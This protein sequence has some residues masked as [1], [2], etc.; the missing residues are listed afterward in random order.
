MQDDNEYLK[1]LDYLYRKSLMLQDT[2]GFNKVLYFY[3]IDSL[4]HI[5]YTAGILAY[6]FGSPKNIIGAEYMRWRIDEEKKGD[7]TK[8]PKFINWLRETK[9]EK[10]TVL[11]S[12]WQMIYDT[13][14]SASYRSFRIVIDPDS[15]A[16]L[17]ANFFNAVIDE[18]FEKEFLKSIYA[19]ASLGTLFTAYCAEH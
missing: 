17:T 6:N 5:D 11:P 7:R 19:E 16:P 4:A 3:L 12:L 14:N 13:E 9:P 1:V 10:F 8:F 15:K 18:F 2:S